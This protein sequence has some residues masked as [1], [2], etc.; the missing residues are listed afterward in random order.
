MH[1]N[2]L[3]QRRVAD[4]TDDEVHQIAYNILTMAIGGNDSG[5][6]AFPSDVALERLTLDQLCDIQGGIEAGIRVCRAKDQAWRDRQKNTHE[7]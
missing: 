4:L 3:A 2:K 6:R 7:S 1:G 5:R